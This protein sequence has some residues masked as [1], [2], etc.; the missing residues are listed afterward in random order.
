MDSKLVCALGTWH[1]SL[2]WKIRRKLCG[3]EFYS[4]HSRGGC[5]ENLALGNWGRLR[6]VCLHT[7]I[8]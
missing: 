4:N 5:P 8:S 3:M 6:P 2:A 7:N 1:I